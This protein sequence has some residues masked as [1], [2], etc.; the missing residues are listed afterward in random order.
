MFIHYNDITERVTGYTI[1]EQDENKVWDIPTIEVAP[2]DFEFPITEYEVNNLTLVHVGKTAEDIA[3][4]YAKLLKEISY[5]IESHLDAKATE[6]RY[7]NIMSAR[8]YAGIQL[9]GT[10]TTEEL[11][12][13]AE[14]VKLA[15]WAR[16]VWA[17]VALIEAD[18]SAGIRPM[19]TVDEAIGLLPI[20]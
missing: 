7:D 11:R 15:Q 10:E 19:P 6:Y 8:S 4:D 18:I 3:A 2:F 14:A 13:N 9:S 12:Q 17:V 5:A 16:K 20:I 1:F